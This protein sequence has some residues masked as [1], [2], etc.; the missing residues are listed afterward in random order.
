MRINDNIYG[1]FEI[2]ESVLID[3]INSPSMQRLKKISQFGMPDEYYFMKGYSR[4][5]HCV[6][7]MLLLRKLGADLKEQ[8]AGL[9]HD[10]SHTAFSHVI[11]WVIGDPLKENY[12]DEVFAQFIENSEIPNILDK[13][14]FNYKEICKLDNFSLLENEL[15]NICADRVDYSLREIIDFETLSNFKTI[16]D[17]LINHRGKIVFNSVNAAEI[18]GMDFARCQREHWAGAQ[19]KA[20]YHVLA[21]VLKNA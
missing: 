3:L 20:R 9:L 10:V 17:S 18:F 2:N 15:P 21:G 19:A 6:G 11:D 7:V 16:L 13:Y 14:N 8:I 12:Q 4:Y 5:D 1:D